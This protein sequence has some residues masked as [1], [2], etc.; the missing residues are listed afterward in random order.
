MHC[1]CSVKL[2]NAQQAKIY[3]NTRPSSNDDGLILSE[4][5]TAPKEKI[6]SD[7]KNFVHLVGLYTYCN[8]M[9]GVYSVKKQNCVTL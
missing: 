6:N 5:C 2:I 3:I 1:A 4:I 7:H 8:M 9:H